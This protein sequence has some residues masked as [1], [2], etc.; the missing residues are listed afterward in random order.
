L[1]GR[2]SES[3]ERRRG[4]W[5]S[6]RGIA[7]VPD[8]EL[9]IVTTGSQGE[10]LAALRRM[11]HREHRQV[12]L[13]AGDTV[14]FSAT[15]I[16]GNERAINDTVDRLFQIGCDVVTARDAPIHTSGHGHREEMKLMLNLTRPR[17]LMPV[18]GDHIDAPALGVEV[19]EAA[20]ATT[21]ADPR[22]GAVSTPESPARARLRSAHQGVSPSSRLEDDLDRPVVLFLEHL[23]GP[24]RLG[25]G[26]LVGGQVVDA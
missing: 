6:R 20:T 8:R 21:A 16:P 9:V 3:S 11:A 17:Y 12:R 25:Q 1:P 15:P 7:K 26:Q 22:A 13:H 23:V 14:V 2:P 10:P 5:S 18:H 19:A 24:G 4:C